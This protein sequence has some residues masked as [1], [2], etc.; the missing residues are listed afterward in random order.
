MAGRKRI[1]DHLKI[2]AGTAQP[3]RMNA[4]A[5]VAASDLP[6]PPDR[7]SARAAEIFAGLVSV[8]EEMGIA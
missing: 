4:D 5:P 8:I 1:P 3:C 6:V 2:V 7:L